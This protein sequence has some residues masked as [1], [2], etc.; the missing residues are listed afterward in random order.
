M[1]PCCC[2]SPIFSLSSF[3]ALFLFIFVS[4][5]LSPS[6]YSTDPVSI[7]PFSSSLVSSL[8]MDGS[9]YSVFSLLI[10][11]PL[12]IHYLYYRS[13]R[14][15][16]VNRPSLPDLSHNTYATVLAP[17]ST[18]VASETRIRKCSTAPLV[19][20]NHWSSIA[21]SEL[22]LPHLYLNC[23]LLYDSS[24]AQQSPGSPQVPVP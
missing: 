6:Y 4:S 23:I 3:L 12:V 20:K 18:T 5:S 14:G 15:Y 10:T 17:M 7:H 22:S 13:P 8:R 11:F 19:H 24:N 9:E 16:P 1:L 21:L 2:L